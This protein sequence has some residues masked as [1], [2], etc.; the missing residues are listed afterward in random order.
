[1]KMKGIIVLTIPVGSIP[2]E[3]IKK[4][5]KKIVRPFASKALRRAGYGIWSIP[6]RDL[7]IKVEQIKF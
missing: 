3:K 5:L 4:C 6:S 2:T 1:M 7:E